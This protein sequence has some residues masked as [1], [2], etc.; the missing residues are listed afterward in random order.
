[1]DHKYYFVLSPYDRSNEVSDKA[2]KYYG[3]KDYD[4]VSNHPGFMEILQKII[5]SDEASFN[6]QLMLIGIT[7]ISMA[8]CDSIYISKDWEND[9]YC[10]ICHA[11]AFSHGL[12]I[13]YET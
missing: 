7:T 8:F 6:T 12:E 9:D 2:E 5:G 13:T 10:K 1:M 4:V 11:L 3:T